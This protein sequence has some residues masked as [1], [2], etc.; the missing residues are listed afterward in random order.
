MD[1]TYGTIYDKA[2]DRVMGILGIKPDE[3]KVYDFCA[4]QSDKRAYGS[5]L[6]KQY[7]EVKVKPHLVKNDS[8]EFT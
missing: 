3:A 7:Y 5:I 2:Y 6:P 4:A 8:K 1:K